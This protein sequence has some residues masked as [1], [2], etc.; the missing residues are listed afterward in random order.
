VHQ[1]ASGGARFTT[2]PAKTGCVA[3]EIVLGAHAHHNRPDP[4]CC[5][6]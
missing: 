6:E 3:Q 2:P 4:Y 5:H 1:E